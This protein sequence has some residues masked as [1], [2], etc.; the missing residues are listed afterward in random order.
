MNVTI[1][2]ISRDS[3]AISCTKQCG[4]TSLHI[5]I[6]IIMIIIVSMI[7]NSDGEQ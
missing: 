2:I 4:D 1:V 7:V 5:I 3:A 6:S